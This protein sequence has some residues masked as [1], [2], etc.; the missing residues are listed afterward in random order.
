[1]KNS[2]LS[3]IKNVD[4]SDL[5]AKVVSNVSNFYKPVVFLCFHNYV[6]FDYVTKVKTFFLN[7]KNEESF[8]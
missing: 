5:I 8:F 1:M 2:F 3:R 6:F 7:T 4:V